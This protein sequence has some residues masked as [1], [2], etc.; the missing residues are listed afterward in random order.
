MRAFVPLLIIII[1]VLLMEVR[2]L[3]GYLKERLQARPRLWLLRRLN[4]LAQLFDEEKVK[5]E[6]RKVGAVLLGGGAL[7]LALRNQQS[8]IEPHEAVVAILAGLMLIL[9]GSLRAANKQESQ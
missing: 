8:P 1:V 5:D 6:V 2:D 7:G 4:T 9:I 3:S